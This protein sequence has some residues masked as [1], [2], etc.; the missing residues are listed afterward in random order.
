MDIYHL[1]GSYPLYEHPLIKAILKMLF[2]RLF[3]L[4]VHWPFF[5]L[6]ILFLF[7]LLRFP[8]HLRNH[9]LQSHKFIQYIITILINNTNGIK[10]TYKSMNSFLHTAFC[11]SKPFHLL[12][13]YQY[14]VAFPCHIKHRSS[15]KRSRAGA[16]LSR[17]IC[18][19]AG[20]R[21][22]ALKNLFFLW[23]SLGMRLR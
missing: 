6:R 14:F 16:I 3:C 5:R 9:G 8:L 23:K 22:K 4:Q 15:G 18:S 17:E 20:I 2:C 19:I 12:L 11:Y 1:I 10:L 13:I 7:C 21:Q